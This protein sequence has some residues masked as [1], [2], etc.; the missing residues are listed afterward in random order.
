MNAEGNFTPEEE[1]TLLPLVSVISHFIGVLYQQQAEIGMEGA[2]LTLT[3]IF[4]A[5]TRFGVEHPE[6][7]LYWVNTLADVYGAEWSR[8]QAQVVESFQNTLA[9]RY[10]LP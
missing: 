4:S 1:Q 9:P 5:A 2:A 7:A 3:T 10:E 8:T 6:S